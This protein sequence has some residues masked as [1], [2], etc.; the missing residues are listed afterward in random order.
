VIRSGGCGGASTW[1]LKLSP[2]NRRI[3]V[4]FEVDQNKVGRR[5]KVVL[6][7]DGA[8]FF[9]GVRETTGPSGSFE[10]RRVTGNGRGP[11]EFVAK[12]T[13]LRSGERCRGSATF[14][15]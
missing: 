1:K 14:R 6:R 15:G 12:A 9:R 3:E 2:E 4:E 13:N 5:W 7:K 8:R 10:L 11:D